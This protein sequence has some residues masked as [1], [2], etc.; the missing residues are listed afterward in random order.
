M[1][2]K[3]QIESGVE[4]LELCN[5]LQTEKDGV[6]RPK[7]FKTDKSKTLD[8]FAMDV[9]QAATNMNSLYMLFPMMNDLAELGR[10]LESE[11]KI[12]VDY[13]DS[14]SRAALNYLLTENGLEPSK[15]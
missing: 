2:W 8:K 9:S 14:L 12:E 13:G 3:K 6:N 15:N 4:L 7:L 10:K 1:D 5:E 11:G